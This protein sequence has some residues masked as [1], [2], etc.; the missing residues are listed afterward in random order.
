[1]S[2]RNRTTYIEP[3][4]EAEPEKEADPVWDTQAEAKQG[5]PKQALAAQSR[6]E[7]EDDDELEDEDSE[8]YDD[9]DIADLPSSGADLQEPAEAGLEGDD[10]APELPL[11]FEEGQE[12]PEADELSTAVE[13]EV[14]SGT[15]GSEDALPAEVLDQYEFILVHD[16]PLDVDE[17]GSSNILDDLEDEAQALVQSEAAEETSSQERGTQLVKMIE[18]EPLEHLQDAF[19]EGEGSEAAVDEEERKAIQERFAAIE[20][21]LAPP[22][23]PAVAY[24]P[25]QPNGKV[26]LMAKISETMEY[27]RQEGWY[28]DLD[29]YEDILKLLCEDPQT[30]VLAQA[31]LNSD[32]L[33]RLSYY[34]LPSKACYLSHWIA[35]ISPAVSASCV[36]LAL[37]DLCLSSAALSTCC[38]RH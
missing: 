1:M 23:K 36:L 22:P 2:C 20:R 13:A 12:G 18:V 10:S 24:H 35:P 7:D 31:I 6:D 34:P 4:I 21:E 5:N 29:T 3:E 37:H 11:D 14:N 9:E 33:V 17:L 32:L 15:E 38:A 16:Q 8:E 19:Q 30:A 26:Q 28:T 25:G 27:G